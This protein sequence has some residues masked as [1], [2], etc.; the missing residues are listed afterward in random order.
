[1]WSPDSPVP[2]L[3]KAEVQDQRPQLLLMVEF[4]VNLERHFIS[5][6]S[7]V[8]RVKCEMDYSDLFLG[9]YQEILVFIT[10]KLILNYR[11]CR[12]ISWEV[13]GKFTYSSFFAMSVPVFV[14]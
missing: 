2:S 9:S 14:R 10:E 8:D 4:L 13:G 6:Q 11:E 12:C 5:R 1:M 7:T 3:F